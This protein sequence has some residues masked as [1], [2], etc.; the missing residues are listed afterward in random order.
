MKGIKKLLTGI[1]AATLIMGMSVTA[2]ATDDTNTTVSQDQTYTLTINDTRTNRSYEAYQIIVG[3]LSVK[4][5]VKTLSNIKWGSGVAK[6]D[7]T[8]TDEEMAELEAL[9]ADNVRE[10]AENL[11]LSDTKYTT[12][13]AS[14]P[15]TFTVPAGWYLVKETTV[16][17]GEDDFKSAFMMEVVGDATA[18]PKGSKTT[19]EKK[20]Q[21]INDSNTEGYSDL[22]DSA[23]YD[24][25]DEIPYTLTATIGSDLTYFD[26]YYIQ[27]VD[28]MSAGL[29]YVDID[30]LT[31]D[32][33]EKSTDNVAVETTGNITT[34]TIAN[35]LDPA[36]G[37][38]E[39]ST[40]VINYR[41][42]LNEN[43]II[44]KAGNPNTVYLEYSNNPHTDERGKTPEDKNIVFTYKVVVNKVDGDL[45]PLAG[46]GFTLYKQVT[47]DYDGDKEVKTGAAI[48]AAIT[49]PSV[50]ADELKDDAL[51]IELTTVVLNANG[52]S[53]GMNGV[54]DGTYV[55]V[56]TTI[57]EG[58]NAWDSKEF[59]VSAEHSQD[60][61]E[62]T[63]TSLDGGD[64]FTGSIDE[65]SLT[66]DIINTSGLV[67]PSTGG[68]GT[69]IFYIIGAVL[70]V[71]GVA[72]FIVR[73]KANAE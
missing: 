54:D 25:G 58:Y 9:T 21:D 27:F 62:L 71:A 57:P 26:E 53:F 20:V 60:P 51:Y 45:N 17:E 19:V 12:Q 41:A 15:Y 61:A 31:V 65:G 32:G 69:T 42:K 38:G 22:Q 43:A 13:G 52:D 14:G 50:K 55:L 36:V 48:K 2:Y 6:T 37:A 33:A 4:G 47:E 64:L 39:G 23:D 3:D 8:V 16:T 56:E 18:S 44:G 63:L 59:I 5:D 1:L 24:I 28:E 70:I 35:I 73:R 66:T 72:Y 30:K 46:A 49:N 34:F 40:I 29:T 67:L 7:K 11:V 10:Y 68:I